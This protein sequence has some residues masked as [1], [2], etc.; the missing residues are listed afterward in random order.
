MVGP[1]QADASRQFHRITVPCA[2]GVYGNG[3]R[4]VNLSF[5]GMRHGCRR[6][7]LK[8]RAGTCA[9]NRAHLRMAGRGRSCLGLGT[10]RATGRDRTRT[11]R[12]EHLPAGRRDVVPSGPPGGRVAGWKGLLPPLVN[13]VRQIGGNRRGPL[14]ESPQ[15]RRRANRAYRRASKKRSRARVRR[16]VLTG[17]L[18]IADLSG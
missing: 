3:G 5:V 14:H 15:P 18:T 11:G 6:D 4:S 8:R 13:R 12:L 10:S 16:A 9:A 2:H 17:T 7:S 1:S